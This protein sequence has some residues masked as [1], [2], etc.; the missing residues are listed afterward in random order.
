M[1]PRS[2]TLQVG[3]PTLFRPFTSVSTPAQDTKTPDFEFQIPRQDDQLVLLSESRWPS[4]RFVFVFLDPARL[5][6]PTL[7]AVALTL[8]VGPN[9]SG[10]PLLAVVKVDPNDDQSVCTGA[11]YKNAL[12]AGVPPP[13]KPV[14]KPEFVAAEPDAETQALGGSYAV[15]APIPIPL[16]AVSQLE[17]SR[18]KVLPTL[19]TGMGIGVEGPV[20]AT[21][22][23][24]TWVFP[25]V[26]PLLIA[27]QLT[28]KFY[29]T[30]D[31][32][33]TASQQIDRPAARNDAERAAREQGE[34]LRLKRTIAD[35]LIGLRGAAPDLAS[36]FNDNLLSGLP[37]AFSREYV[38]GLKDLAF[39]RELAA[40]QL[41]AWLESDLFTL[42]DDWWPR[43][44]G[45]PD[46]DYTFY[47]DALLGGLARL[48]EA[49]HGVQYLMDVRN[50]LEAGSSPVPSGVLN[51][52][53]EFVFRSSLSSPQQLLIATKSA[54]SLLQTWAAFVTAALGV[55]QRVVRGPNPT[56]S[57]I[58][59]LQAFANRLQFV[60]Q[61]GILTV[62]IDNLPLELPSPGVKT[63]VVN[64]PVPS[65]KVGAVR[66]QLQRAKLTT[67]HLARVA[68]VLSFGAAYAALRAALTE[69]GDQRAKDMAMADLAGASLGVIDTAIAL[70]VLDSFRS[71][72]AG[73]LDMGTK[74]LGN[75]VSATLG[76]LAS[77]A[78]LV[79]ASLA[80]ADSY[81]K[82]D[83]DQA[84]SHMTEG[85]GALLIGVGSTVILV[86]G[87]TGPFALWTIV[88]GTGISA[89][90]FI[91]SVFAADT[92]IDQM[93]KFCAFGQQSGQAALKPPGWS[94]C[95]VSFAEWDATTVPGLLNQLK[96]F[97][98]IFYAFEASGAAPVEPGPLASDGILRLTPSSLRLSCSFV[99]N[100]TA[101]YSLPAGGPQVTRTGTATIIIPNT[102]A[103][104]PTLV[105]AGGNYQTA[106]AIRRHRD[107]GRD[108]LDVRFRPV[109][110]IVDK[111]SAR[112]L[113]LRDLT[114]LVQL[115]V[116]GVKVDPSGNNNDESLVVPTT[117]KGTTPLMVRPVQGHALV[118]DAQ[119]SVKV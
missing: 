103:G 6:G 69:G 34:I 47:V 109:T 116:P 4:T 83:W 48:T 38:R 33:L 46:A 70:P 51:V 107:G 115:Q 81:D 59:D 39:E 72:M 96:A 117:A 74:L 93:L 17:T 85:F 14:A 99:I 28:R 111:A 105:D 24:P 13:F 66:Q 53:N 10:N 25:V 23:N 57:L 64:I 73:K 92:E 68:A 41:V 50:R 89:A 27:E 31:N 26:D 3:R 98:Q 106:G 88:A 11:E 97:Q 60:F 110:Q 86:S 19:G 20:T 63:T 61:Q 113:E 91:W 22:N 77:V 95:A 118:A 29:E 114:C 18:P 84:V 90:G 15:A 44:Q 35:N 78:S 52:T 76:L 62:Q 32:F 21:P 104:S 102:Q 16:T 30:A 71:K 9:A 45:N 100:Y 40:F 2:S 8:L 56:T 80:T 67:A 82:G 112:P 54:A 5:V 49:D 87:T 37:D 42:A 65:F 75:R 36:A 101:V 43:K 94:Q 7:E 55:R 79:S 108:A 119:L 58:Q 12:S 1:G